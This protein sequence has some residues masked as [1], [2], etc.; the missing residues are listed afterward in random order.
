MSRSLSR[1][2]LSLSRSSHPSSVVGLSLVV[3][4]A[5]TPLF[6]DSLTHS[7]THY[8]NHSTDSFLTV[9]LSSQAAVARLRS[10][11]VLL[12]RRENSGRRLGVHRAQRRQRQGPPGPQS[13]QAQA[14]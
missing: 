12:G 6:T 2:P 3:M 7:L 14:V 10:E 4:L 13:T 11:R 8:L 1:R 5:Q 9:F